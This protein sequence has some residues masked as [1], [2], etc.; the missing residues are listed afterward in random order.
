MLKSYLELNF[1]IIKKADKSTYAN[2]SDIRL[3]NLGPIALFSNIILTKSSGKRLEDISPTHIV[4]LMYK[5]ISSAKDAYLSFGFDRSR[6]RR[7][8]ELTHNKNVKGKYH[9][10]IMLKDVFGFAEH[11]KKLLTV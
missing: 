5:L 1:E 6:D 2:G 8:Q 10:R 3:I 7:K 4:S 9:L 11:Q